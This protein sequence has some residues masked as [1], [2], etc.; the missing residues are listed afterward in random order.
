MHCVV[1]VH[2]CIQTQTTFP[3]LAVCFKTLYVMTEA[4]YLVESPVEPPLV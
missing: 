2:Q 1:T 4:R 3:D